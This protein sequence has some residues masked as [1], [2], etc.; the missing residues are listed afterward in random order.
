[1]TKPL[2]DRKRSALRGQLIAYLAETMPEAQR[3]GFEQRLLNEDAFSEQIHYA[4]QELLEDYAAGALSAV[5]RKQLGPWILSSSGRRQH[6]QLTSDLLYRAR[7]SRAIAVRLALAI[8]AACV[9]LFW[10]LRSLHPLQYFHGAPP[11]PAAH[12]NQPPPTFIAPG[13]RSTLE[14]PASIASADAPTAIQPV[15]V[16]LVPEHVRGESLPT[17]IYSYTIPA[18]SP[19]LLQILVPSDSGCEYSVTIHAETA[20]VADRHIERVAC[21]TVRDSQ[22]VD[23][24]LPPGSLPP[25]QYTA[26]ISGPDGSLMGRFIVHF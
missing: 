25:G 3:E 7:H 24:D 26:R 10:G 11:P 18:P 17:V 21:V 8:T 1:V 22:Y 9:L 13:E 6:V 23:V 14:D 2:S 16:Q 12:V 5:H 4:Q 20:A 19:I 15:V